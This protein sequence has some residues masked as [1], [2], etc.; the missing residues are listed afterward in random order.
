MY[1]NNV[2]LM[3]HWRNTC[4]KRCLLAFFNFLFHLFNV[5]NTKIVYNNNNNKN[6]N[7]IKI[8][9]LV[10]VVKRVPQSP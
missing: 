1:D 6:T 5:G 3:R 7:I 9:L 10:T 4:M 8:N 2:Y